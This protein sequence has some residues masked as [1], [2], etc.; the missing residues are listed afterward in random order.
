[1]SR[2]LE[3]K[4]YR[5]RMLARYELLLGPGA[6]TDKKSRPK[7]DGAQND[8][9]S[10]GLVSSTGERERKEVRARKVKSSVARFQDCP[11]EE[12]LER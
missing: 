3:S 2:F 11:V 5:K 10:K 1:M 7:L 8:K 4:A 9:Q 12:D 6:E